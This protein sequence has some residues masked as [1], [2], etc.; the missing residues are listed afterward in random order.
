M[1]NKFNPT[2]TNIETTFTAANFSGLFVALKLACGMA[3]NA[4]SPTIS[5]K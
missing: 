4:S 5:I 1:K 3:T 2:L